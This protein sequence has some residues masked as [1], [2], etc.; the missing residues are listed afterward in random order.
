MASLEQRHGSVLYFRSFV[1]D[2]ESGRVMETTNEN[3]LRDD[4]RE[5][6][7][8]EDEIE[9]LTKTEDSCEKQRWLDEEDVVE[10]MDGW[11]GGNRQGRAC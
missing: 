7:Y 10:R 3:V 11:M 8:D 9:N 2:P 4:D 1:E 6:E 5:L